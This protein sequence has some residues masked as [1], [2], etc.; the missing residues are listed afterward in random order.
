MQREGDE[1][2][3]VEAGLFFGFDDEGV[4]EALGVA[5]H[6][7]GGDF[8]F[9][10]A[11][12]TEFAD[13]NSLFGAD[14]RP[15]D[16]ARHGAMGVEVARAGGGV[17]GG[18]R[19]VVAVVLEG[20]EGVLVVAKEAGG[21]VAR[22]VGSEALDG[23][24]DALA[25]AGRTGGVGALEFGQTMAEAGRVELGDLEDADAT[26]RASDAAGEM[27]AALLDGAGEFGV[28][29][30]DETVVAGREGAAGHGWIQDTG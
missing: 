4:F 24:G 13:A 9:A 1:C 23:V 30:L 17:E 26:L 11:D 7:A 28:N 27:R 16:A 29:D 6:F 21:D 2:F 19:L 3:A 20:G 14:G 8:G 25:H 18:A 5:L 22:K 15:E 10:G 12:E